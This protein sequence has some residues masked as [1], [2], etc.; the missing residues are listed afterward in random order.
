MAGFATTLGSGAMTNSLADLE[1][2]RCI[3]V[4]GSNTTECHPLVARRIMRAKARGAVLLVA[5]PR[6]I[7]LSGLA[8][9]A[10]QPRPGSDIALLNGMMHII[11]ANGWHDE[12]YIAE[13]TEGFED[14]AAVLDEYPPERAAEITGLPKETIHRMAELYAANRPAAVC[15]AMGITQYASGVDRVKAC[16]NLALLTGNIGV[17]GGGI[18]PLRGQNNVQGACDAGA[19]PD[20]FP[21]YQKAAEPA[22]REKFAS[23]WGTPVPAEPGLTVSEM[24]P[25][26]LDG[27]IK[28]LYI[29]GENPALSDPDISHVREALSRLDLLVVQDLFPTQT[30]EF[31]HVIL[32][33]AAS[34]E[35]DGTFTNT[36]RRCSRIRKAVDPPGE[37]LADWQILV[38]LARE[39]GHAWNYSAPEDIFAEM[40]ALNPGYAGMSYARLGIE[41]LQWP[42]PTPD[43]PGTA[44]LHQKGF[45]RGKALFSPIYQKPP[46]EEPDADY[47]LVLSTG[48]MFAQFHTATMTGN[49][50]HLKSEAEE[51][52]LEMHPADAARLGIG[53]DDRVR[54][55]SRRGRIETKVKLTDTVGAG[56]VFMTFHFADSPANLLTNTALDPSAKIPELKHCAVRVERA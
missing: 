42:C 36:E 21:G 17:A 51:G 47:P 52:Y 48:R 6:R 50:P 2:A 3:F 15:Y 9:L 27:R 34:A 31:A 20:V 12:G 28:A 54:I 10:V 7:Q 16:A 29:M 18:N 37:A 40:A 44:I 49:S 1:E 35:K 56:M 26:I 24:I 30:S 53:P 46:S 41:G 43:H 22:V 33:A 11:K 55:T 25:A 5:D 14:L 39:M 19:L 32:P 13:R 45:A 4:I 38:R 23:A 8:D